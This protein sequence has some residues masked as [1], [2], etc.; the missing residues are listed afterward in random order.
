MAVTT[1]T[2]PQQSV[3]STWATIADVC[4]PCNTYTLDA[5]LLQDRLLVASGILYGLTGRQWAGVC[6][7][8]IRPNAEYGG[9]GPGRGFPWWSGEQ[10]TATGAA[11]GL[12]GVCGCRADGSTGCNL[13]S[14]VRLPRRPV[15]GIQSVKLDG[16]VLDPSFYRVDDWS[17]L[18]Y[19][20]GVGDTRS[21]WPCCQDLTKASTE[22]N[23][24]EVTYTYGVRPP[25]E[26]VLAAAVL[27]CH[28]A[29][30]VTD[31]GSCG[32][33]NRV[34]NIVRQGVTVATVIDDM[35]KMEHGWTGLMEVD[36]F[37]ASARE[38]QRTRR[39]RIVSP[40]SW[41]RQR[42]ITSG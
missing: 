16:V 24:F 11:A 34:R 27:G 39:S 4:S 30:N 14:V 8:R 23:T 6:S 28:L 7:D 31:P 15:I 22:T 41:H 33:N 20:P 17:K 26:G 38:A 29:L 9:P 10:I 1:T 40:E 18:T 5:G 19:L 42:R 12:W 35:A 37:I 2:V 32:L 36:L 25:P 13:L 3:C 21:G